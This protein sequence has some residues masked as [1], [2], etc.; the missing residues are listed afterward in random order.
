MLLSFSNTKENQIAVS[1]SRLT[2]FCMRNLTPKVSLDGDIITT[3][4]TEL[5]KFK[6]WVKRNSFFKKV[7]YRERG[8]IIMY[9]KNSWHFHLTVSIIGI[10]P[11]DGTTH[12]YTQ[13]TYH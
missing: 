12:Y 3:D 6:Y 7:Q 9:L 1:W 5:V 10:I 11:S 13:H 4:F 8:K 2:S